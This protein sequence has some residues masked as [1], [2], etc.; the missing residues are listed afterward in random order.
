MEKKEVK[1]K[2]GD[3][4]ALYQ[5]L[6]N[7]K[8]KSLVL[9]AAIFKTLEGLKPYYEYVKPQNYIPVSEEFQKYEQAIR[10]VN[11][12]VSKGKTKLVG[13]TE[14]YDIDFS[15]LIY[16][17]KIEKVNKEFEKAI[18]EREDQISKWKELLDK[19]FEDDVILHKVDADKIPD[20]AIL[21]EEDF[22]V[23]SLLIK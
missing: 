14:V 8:V 22:K 1:W 2:V 7:I 9:S 21:N 6:D 13:N 23:L 17:K 19:D 10:E 3:V 4:Y 15:S 20:S 5:K 18:K 16:R 11:Q 12:E